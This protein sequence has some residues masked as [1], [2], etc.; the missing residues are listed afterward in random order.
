M[1]EVHTAKR[2]TTSGNNNEKNYQLTRIADAL[3]NLFHE[4]KEI[5]A[6]LNHD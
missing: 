5:H 6:V 3:E 4:L 2:D 1:Y